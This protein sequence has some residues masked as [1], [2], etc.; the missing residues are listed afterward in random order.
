MEESKLPW[1]TKREAYKNA[2]NYIK[3]RKD[4]LIKSIKTP[5]QRFNDSAVDGF[6]WHS[7]IVIGGRPAVDKTMIKDQIIREAFNLNKHT[8]FRVLE[9]QFEMVAKVGAIREY[10][11][12]LSKSY[13]QVCSADNYKISDDDFKKCIEYSKEKVNDPIEIVENPCTV[14]EFEQFIEAWFEYH[15]KVVGNDKQYVPGIIT[16]DHSLLFKKTNFENDRMDT[17]YHLGEALTRLKRK[18]PVIFIILSQLNRNVD[19]VERT[20]DGKH[21][22]YILD[23]DIFGSDALLQHADIVV[24][25]N[26]PGAKNIRIY[27]PERWIIDDDRVLV[28]HFLKVRN[29]DTRMSFFRAEFEKMSIVETPPPPRDVKIK[30]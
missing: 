6:E 17:L 19:S 3:S 18:Y 23:S 5:W 14:N 21:G 9:F 13:K 24:A 12:V 22:N 8:Y 25:F 27:G 7:M 2:L 10:S 11:S 20:G 28:A 15:A 26:R 16:V 30:N 4:G 29:G 1:I